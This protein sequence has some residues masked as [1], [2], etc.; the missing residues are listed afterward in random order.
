MLMVLAVVGQRLALR[1]R[2]P[3]VCG[4]LAAGLVLGASG[5]DAVRPDGSGALVGTDG[6]HVVHAFSAIWLAFEVGLGLDWAPALRSWALPGTVALSTVAT[7]VLIPLGTVGLAGL[8][9]EPALLVGA[10]GCL[11]GPFVVSSLNRSEEAVLVGVIGSGVGLL[12]L[13]A[14]LLL[15]HAQ[16][17]VPPDAVVAMGRFWA[18]LAAGSLAIEVLWRAGSFSRRAPTIVA[19]LG[20]S[21][22]AA[23]FV[24]SGQLYALPLGFGAGIVL[25]VHEESSHLLRHL[26]RPARRLAAMVFFGLVAATLDLGGTLWPPSIAVLKIVLIQAVI[27]ILV[28]GVG[29]AIWFPEREVSG[30]SRHRSWLLLPRGALIYELVCRPERGLASFL[31]PDSARLVEQLATAEILLY[32]LVFAAVAAALVRLFGQDEPAPAV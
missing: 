26:L 15:L 12:A 1:L 31:P 4:W 9:W 8:A 13:T 25:A 20:V 24:T 5:L 2:L 30:A 19:L 32:G 11:W 23:V 3:P 16:R 21:V 18:S 28:R 22:L 27:L 29:A 17:F 10:L 14:I 6:L 7:L